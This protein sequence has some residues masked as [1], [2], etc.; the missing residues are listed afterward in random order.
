MDLI[1][2][3]SNYLVIIL[4]T[5]IKSSKDLSILAKLLGGTFIKEKKETPFLKL[6]FNI[7]PKTRKALKLLDIITLDI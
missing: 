2:S 1:Y 7:G 6:S 4:S 5:H 3:L